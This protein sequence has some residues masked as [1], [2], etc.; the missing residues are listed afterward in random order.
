MNVERKNTSFFSFQ[1]NIYA[2]Q[3]IYFFN[4]LLKL[5]YCLYSVKRKE[6]KAYK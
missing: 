5:F 3:H 1:E 2:V 6:E 4:P